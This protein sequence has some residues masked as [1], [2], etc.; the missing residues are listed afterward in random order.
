MDGNSEQMNESN[1]DSG[2]NNSGT[3]QT[4]WSKYPLNAAKGFLMGAADVVPGVSGGTMAL[5]VGIYDKL[6]HAIT[7][8][9]AQFIKRLLSFKLKDALDR[10]DW[11]FLVMLFTGILGAIVFFT[12]IVPLQTLMFT[13]PELIYGL[14]FG[15]ITGS[16]ILLI[17][18]LKQITWVSLAG[19][20]IGTVIGYLV[21]NLV[22]TSTPETLPFVFMSGSIAIT[23]MILPGISGSFL[24]LILG[25]YQFI[26]SQIAALGGPET[27]SAITMLA[28]F[29]VGMV[30]GLALFSRVL[31]WLLDH[32]YLFTITVLIG[33][34]IGSLMVIWPFQEREFKEFSEEKT[35]VAD[36][37]QVEEWRSM[38]KEGPEY[39]EV[40]SQSGDEVTVKRVKRKLIHSEPYWPDQTEIEAGEITSTEKW[41]GFGAIFVGLFI[42]AVV[43]K[44]ADTSTILRV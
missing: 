12:R 9:D 11:P 10:I 41:T 24:L 31:S 22:P 33:F 32:V 26:L 42:I 15:L 6:I 1:S 18:V 35:V 16:V 30:V 13:Q 19:L 27:W 21:V 8:V 23:A 4:S 5:I 43:G 38:S 28:T 44:L 37:Q 20:A 2:E 3:E 17:Y 29:A 34:L 40:L 25:K 14:Y 36:K 39:F 7:S